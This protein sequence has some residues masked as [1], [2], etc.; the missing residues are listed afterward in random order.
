[1]TIVGFAIL[2]YR[3]TVDVPGVVVTNPFGLESFDAI[4]GPVLAVSALTI[5]ACGFIAFAS[6][7]VRYRRAD[8]ET[9]QQLRWLFAVGGGMGVCL[10]LLFVFGPL[11]ENLGWARPIA[12]VLVIVL[13]SLLAIGIPVATAVAVFRYHLYD[14]NLVIRKTVVYS[15]LV[16]FVTIVYAGV[17][18]GLFQ[19]VEITREPLARN[20]SLDCHDVSLA[21]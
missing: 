1:M 7:I 19:L 12:D 5:L 20:G 11:S 6:L 21:R 2:P 9:R 3:A 13:V 10:L 16:G 4:L 15:V 17:V 8:A 18:A 14:L